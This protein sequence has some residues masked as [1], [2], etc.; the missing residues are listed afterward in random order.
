MSAST[1]MV[2]EKFAGKMSLRMFALEYSSWILLIALMIIGTAA[3]PLFFTPGNFI[4][5]LYQS[6]IVGI[7]AIGQFV[8][9]LTG[10]IDLGVGSMLALSAIVGGL[11]VSIAPPIGILASLIVCGALGAVNGAI[12]VY[13]RMPPFIVT[14]GMLAIAR[15]LALTITSGGPVNLGKSWFLAI[16]NGW[17]PQII[18]FGVILTVFVLLVQFPVGRHIY[19]IGGNNEAARVSGINVS[20]VL[21]LV[22][23]LSAICAAIGGLIFTA[24]STV[25]LP[26]Y[27]QGYELQTIAACVLGGTDL[28]GGSG[29]LS[30]VI[31]GVIILSMLGNI[32]TL[33]GVDPFWNFGAIGAALWISVAFRSRL[34]SR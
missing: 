30:G 12:V 16:G 33:T 5:L 19:A 26:T 6:S 32:L 22:Y 2:G 10:G 27:G 24:R 3:S 11:G 15:G 17:W 20:G 29:K 1:P 18:W 23:A 8:V 21:I 4:D 13:G 25:A 7:M 31:L 34:A 9:I 14:F 28:F